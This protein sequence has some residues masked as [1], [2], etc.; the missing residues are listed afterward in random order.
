MQRLLIIQTSFIGDVIL[1]TALAESLHQRYPEAHIDMLV[2]KGN[3]SLFTEHPFLNHV[4]VW[5]KGSGKYRNLFRLLTTIRGLKYDAV[6]N[7]QRFAATGLLTA[8]SGANIRAGFRKNPWAFRFTHK[9]KHEISDD[10]ASP[11]EI[12]R[13]HALLSWSSADAAMPRLYPSPGDF[14]AI[15]PF[16]EGAFVTLAPSS[17]WFTK[18][19]PAE[20]WR[21]LVASLDV[22]VYLIGAPSELEELEAIGHG[23]S[24]VENLAGKLGLL[25]S[26]ALM[27]RAR[28]NVV[29]D[30]APL[31]LASAISAP[32]LALFCSTVPAFGFGP[33]GDRATVMQT[34]EPLDCRP[35]GLHGLK[36]CPKGH[37]KC[38]HTIEVQRVLQHIQ[39]AL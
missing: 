15:A 30:S 25:Q 1:A 36:A 31:H 13:N 34:E 7:P 26:A 16:A 33:L 5:D 24:H 4:H 14:D 19:W 17:V 9:I 21:S 10:P 27:S 11:H 37:F 28:M 38:A 18:R 22:K 12:E 2:R 32:V 20:H 3:E 29:N 8:M 39:G 23:L 6:V 35:C